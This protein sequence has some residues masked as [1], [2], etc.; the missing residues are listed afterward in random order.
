MN[1]DKMPLA[2]IRRI[3]KNGSWYWGHLPFKNFENPEPW[4]AELDSAIEAALD[5][6]TEYDTAEKDGRLLRLP[7]KIG[8]RVYELFRTSDSRGY[9]NCLTLCAGMIE[10][11]KVMEP[12]PYYD[13][14]TEDCNGAFDKN[15]EW[16]IRC[17]PFE[18]KHMRDILRG[19]YIFLTREEAETAMEQEIRAEAALKEREAIQ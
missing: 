12:C 6:L 15:R 19:G 7:C 3:L 13:S 14:E 1:K 18:F 8:E 16:N 2:E 4:Q 5:A 9:H 17:V 11:H 10:G